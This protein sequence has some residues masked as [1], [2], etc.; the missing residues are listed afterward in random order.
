MRSPRVA[1]SAVSSVSTN[2]KKEKQQWRLRRNMTQGG[3]PT[4]P[5]HSEEG[6]SDCS[7]LILWMVAHGNSQ[8]VG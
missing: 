3:K 2:K 4:K 1:R 7:F 5:R 8:L 6:H